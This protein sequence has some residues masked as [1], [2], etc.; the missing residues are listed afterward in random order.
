[1]KLAEIAKIIGANELPAWLGE[2]EVSGYSIDSRTVKPGELFFAIRG[3]KFDGH[4]F[5]AAAFANASAA[6]VSRPVDVGPQLNERRL[7]VN[8]TLRALQELAAEVLRHWNRPVIGIT[9]SAGKTTTKELTAL[10]L[11]R[12]GHVLKSTGN[13]NNAFGLP[14]SV[15]RMETGGARP[16]DYDFAVLEMGMSTPGEIRRLCE[17]APP[18][19][20][21]VTNVSAVH[22]EFFDS[23]HGIANAKAEIV[24]GLKPGGLAVLNA[25]DELVSAMRARHKGPVKMFGI[26]H[27][28]DVIATDLKENG[29]LGTE[30]ILK[31]PRGG[32]V[33][34]L[35]IAG[36]HILYNAL[37]AAAIG[38]HYGL[39]PAQIAEALASAR[40]ATHRGEVLKFRDGFIVVDDSYNSNPRALD[41]MVRMLAVVTGMERKIVV[42]GEM[43]ELG[44]SG[45][46]MHRKS[47]ENIAA[48]K[49]DQLIGVRGLAAEIIAGARSAGMPEARTSYCASSEEAAV[50]LVEKIKPGDLVLVKGSRGVKTEL[51][52]DALKQRFELEDA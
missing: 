31:T 13:L 27:T 35:P 34:R 49:I 28:A 38:D 50:F 6:V 40:A 32:A 52:V 47:G 24:E 23:I 22:L 14:L 51:I 46:D 16:E 45:P 37:V 21:A 5:L 48:N 41:E 36:R 4:D 25:D 1:M 42:A 3:E 39:T 12:K 10:V 33:T 26:E 17:I 30:F 43:L 7:I 9:G 20:A 18:D 29:L 2:I 44:A 11:G 19:V 15:L 8:D